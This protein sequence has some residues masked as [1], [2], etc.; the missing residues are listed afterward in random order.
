MP[1]ASIAAKRVLFGLLGAMTATATIAQ[2]PA[3]APAQVPRSVVETS[4][5]Q[6]VPEFRD[7][8]TG[9]VWNQNNVG[10]N[11]IG[12][13]TAADLAF[14]PLAQAARIDGVVIQRPTAVRLGWSQP[15][16][17]PN[18]PLVS[19]DD[20]SLSA[21]AGK[22]WQVVVYVNNNANGT[23]VPMID[24]R[25]TNAGKTVQ[26]TR[27]LVP[28]LGAGVRAGLVIYGPKTDLFV[29]RAQCRIVSP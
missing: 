2:T 27:A 10:T 16:A 12:T 5:T 25:F 3:Q 11:P 8:K 28:A 23:M 14:D 29:D 24:C 21:V 26:E 20:A 18:V 6:A 1:M 15:S 17:G 22:R 13:P 9:R 4:A 19:L 7:P